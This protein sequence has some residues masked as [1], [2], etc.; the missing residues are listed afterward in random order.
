MFL[1]I[2]VLYHCCVFVV[3]C[4]IAGV[5]AYCD[6]EQRYSVHSTVCAV[7]ICITH[8]YNTILT[9]PKYR[10][11]TFKSNFPSQ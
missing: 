6:T 7:Y 11:I 4:Y 2:C 5:H 3:L 9:Q 8:K 10:V 1:Y